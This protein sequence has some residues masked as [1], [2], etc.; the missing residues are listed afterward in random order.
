PLS[1]GAASGPG[2]LQPED[3]LAWQF[4]NGTL[5]PDKFTPESHVV[6]IAVDPGKIRTMMEDL[7]TLDPEL[8]AKM[9]AN[10]RGVLLPRELLE[11]LNKRVGERFQVTGMG[12]DKGI[13]LTFEIVGQLPE[14]TYNVG[15]MDWDYL[16]TAI[17]EYPRRHGERHPLAHKRVSMVQLKV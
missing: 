1:R 11:S 2:D 12:Y 7:D 6:L 17:D 10:R 9:R 15:I 14:G 3:W 13:D 8:V 5:D 4:Y 16:N